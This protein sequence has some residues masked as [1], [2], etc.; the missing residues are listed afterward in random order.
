MKLEK[1]KITDTLIESI[2]ERLAQGKPV[3]RTLPERGRLHID[4]P[5]PFLCVYRRPPERD[6]HGTEKLVQGEASYLIAS[7]Q[8][9]HHPDLTKLVTKIATIL[10]QEYGAFL[11]VEIW[12]S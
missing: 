7:G 3:R 11:V 9:P 2:C 5:L 1:A 4:R 8:P 12:A 10:S 6:D